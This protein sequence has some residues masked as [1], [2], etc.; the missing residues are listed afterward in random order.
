M[1]RQFGSPRVLA[2]IRNDIKLAESF[3]AGLPVRHYAP[4]SRAA[5]DYAALGVC[6][7]QLLGD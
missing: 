4:G 2:G 5:L 6:L 7:T 3:A 1:A